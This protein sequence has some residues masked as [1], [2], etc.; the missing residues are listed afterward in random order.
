MATPQTQTPK[1]SKPAAKPPT[2]GANGA[3][4]TETTTTET[5]ETPKR[6]KKYIF[7]VT[8]Q[9]KQFENAREAEAFLNS[10]EDVPETF[11]VIKG[12]RIE[13]KQKVSLR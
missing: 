6:A 2:N 3:K 11:E 7:I 9:I 5:E 12:S 4:D 1:D 13:Q 10:G 8:G